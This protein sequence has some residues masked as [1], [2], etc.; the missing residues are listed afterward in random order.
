MNLHF[1]QGSAEMAVSVPSFHQG[2]LN[3]SWRIHFQVGHKMLTQQGLLTR[4]PNFS[5]RV[6]LWSYLGILTA[7]HWGSKSPYSQNRK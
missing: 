2:A 7:W 3:W 4:D 5:P 6:S 1:G